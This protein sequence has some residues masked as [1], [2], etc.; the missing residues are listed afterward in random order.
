MKKVLKVLAI[1]LFGFVSAWILHRS[2]NLSKFNRTLETGGI[3]LEE[4]A[5]AN[6]AMPALRESL[7]VSMEA[8]D[9]LTTLVALANL[10]L[11]RAGDVADAHDFLAGHVARYYVVYGPP[12]RPWTEVSPASAQSIKETLEA[13]SAE[14]EVN[15]VLVEAI[16]EAQNDREQDGAGQPDNHPEKPINQLD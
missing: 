3:S 7:L 11:L 15:P 5:A 6:E 9:R 13:I 12:N 8:G 2:T 1:F 4:L 16:Q 10:R 14:I